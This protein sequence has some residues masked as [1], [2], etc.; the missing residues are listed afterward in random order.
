MGM[1][2]LTG[3]GLALAAVGLL[4]T[5]ASAEGTSIVPGTS[6]GDFY[7]GED[8]PS[9]VTTLGPLHSQD[10][11]PGHLLTG[12][13]WPLKRIG[14]IADKETDKIVALA[15]SLDAAYQTEK[16][17]GA[18]TEMDSIRSAY[19]PEDSVESHEEDDTLIY[20]KL[21]VAFV[22]DKSGALG[23]RVS[24]ILVFTAGHYHDIFK[25]GS[26]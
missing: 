6:I 9:I 3:C 19:G 24:L 15:I 20:D 17:V 23:S 16:G 1:R 25:E 11:L 2:R 10:D 8:L 7:L 12:Y 22:V 13:F 5:A 18:G 14:V 26:Q 4:A 21:G